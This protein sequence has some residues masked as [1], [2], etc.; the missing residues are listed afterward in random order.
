MRTM[1]LA[2]GPAMAACPSAVPAVSHPVLLVDDDC[3]IRAVLA[4]ALAESGHGVV[5][6]ADGLEAVRLL[7]AG[8]EPSLVV[9]DL[10][11]PRLDG[12]GVL[13][14]LRARAADHRPPVLV[15]SSVAELTPPGADA[16][17]TKP[18]A[19]DAFERA[20]ARLTA[21]TH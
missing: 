10:M 5:E 8:L 17:L 14:R 11:M 16:F 12:W 9:L 1:E 13:E 15:A 6:A 3:E 18:F 2:S 21:A 20:V 7:E 4:V 19:L